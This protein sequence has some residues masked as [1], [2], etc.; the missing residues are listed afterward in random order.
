MGDEEDDLDAAIR[1]FRKEFRCVMN[2]QTIKDTNYRQ[3]S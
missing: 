2:F 3:S 1:L